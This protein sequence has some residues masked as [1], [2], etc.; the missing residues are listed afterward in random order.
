VS[1]QKQA[2]IKALIAI[3][4]AGG[5]CPA[6]LPGV[7]SDLPKPKTS[8]IQ[9][10][11]HCAT[12]TSDSRAYYL[13]RLAEAYLS[14]ADRATVD[15]QFNGDINR[16]Y[17]LWSKPDGKV[18]VSWVESVSKAERILNRKTAARKPENFVLADAATKQALMELN[19]ACDS[20][21]KINLYFIASRLFKKSGN[22]SEAE[23]CNT[24]LESAIHS[25][26][27]GPSTDGEQMRGASSVLDSMAYGVIPVD[28]P[29]E[30]LP[31][32]ALPIMKPYKESDFKVCE[33]L[34]LRAIAIADRFEPSEH[35]RRKAHRD[36]VLWYMAL[37]KMDKATKEKQNLFGLVGVSD[38]SIL[39][40]RRETCGGGSPVWWEKPQNAIAATEVPKKMPM[41]FCGMG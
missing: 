33:K 24:I 2:K 9:Q 1:L 15:K 32:D 20:F 27:R 4:F 29:D 26:E 17:G 37:G 6:T 36:L 22:Y 23:K 11:V 34:K 14:G 10:I 38:D 19:T 40:P 16:P 39:Y 12:S 30:R 31:S 21:Q 18:L 25:C 3:A 7:C 5:I 13:L 35:L 41:R 8:L 28:I